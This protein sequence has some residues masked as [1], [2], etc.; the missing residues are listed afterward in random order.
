MSTKKSI[1][2]ELLLA[3]NALYEVEVIED[4]SLKDMLTRLHIVAQHIASIRSRKRISKKQLEKLTNL[5]KWY[6]SYDIKRLEQ[7]LKAY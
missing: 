2:E 4:M 7:D 5:E 3:W 1:D 6:Q